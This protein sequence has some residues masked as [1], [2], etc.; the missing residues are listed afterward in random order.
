M[1]VQAAITAPS[2]TAY[3]IPPALNQIEKVGDPWCIINKGWQLEIVEDGTYIIQASC[4]FM[5]WS[6]P[7]NWYQY[8]ENV[9]LLKQ[10]SSWWWLIQTK[11]QWRA[12]ANTSSHSDQLSTLYTWWFTKGTI[13]TVW[14]S[15]TYWSSITL[16]ESISI[17]RLA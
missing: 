13:F 6:T 10:N 3:Y 16:Q 1:I 9:A 14:A 8:I 17:Q 4:L 15:H 11:T 12:C 5:F 2:S 7:A